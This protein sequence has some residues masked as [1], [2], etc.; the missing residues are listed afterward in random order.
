MWF[1]SWEKLKLKDTT[2]RNS[3]VRWVT[4]HHL[5]HF[6]FT[7]I[8]WVRL[9]HCQLAAPQGKPWRGCAQSHW[10]ADQ[11]AL[12]VNWS[13][14]SDSSA[15]SLMGQPIKCWI[16]KQRWGKKCILLQG[17]FFSLFLSLRVELGCVPGLKNTWLTSWTWITKKKKK[18]SWTGKVGWCHYGSLLFPVILVFYLV[19]S[20]FPGN[21]AKVYGSSQ[22][23]GV[24]SLWLECSW[25]ELLRQWWRKRTSGSLPSL[26]NYNYSILGQG[27]KSP[28]IPAELFCAQNPKD[29]VYKL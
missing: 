2:R 15:L 20:A 17:C 18:T 8:D 23:V 28:T 9:A 4:I 24:V 11:T 3:V 7:G 16:S 27:T 29:Y 19:L 6:S 21:K 1:E 5:A 25:V 10:A 12:R 13:P 26:I 22:K 14:L